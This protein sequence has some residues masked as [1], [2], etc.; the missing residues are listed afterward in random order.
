VKPTPTKADYVCGVGCGKKGCPIKA[1]PTSK[2]KPGK[3]G[4]VTRSLK[5]IAIPGRQQHVRDTIKA[6]QEDELEWNIVGTSAVS[7]HGKF[8]SAPLTA[9]VR[10]IEGCT[11]VA[12]V[13]D[14]GY[15]L[16]HFVSKILI[17]NKTC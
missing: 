8:G 10:G 2:S 13:S 1:K 6:N 17:F 5:D 16:A 9:W 12:I 4:K 11:G 14:H 15:W 3:S 7:K